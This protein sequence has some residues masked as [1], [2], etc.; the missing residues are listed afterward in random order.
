MELE[1]ALTDAVHT[2]EREHGH[3]HGPCPPGCLAR[4]A[5]VLPYPVLHVP[6]DPDRQAAM[7]K[8]N[9]GGH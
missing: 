3:I 2:W 5:D 4:P 1:E 8:L 7:L 6:H 9:I